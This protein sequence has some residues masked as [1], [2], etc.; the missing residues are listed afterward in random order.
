MFTPRYFAFASG[1]SS[2]SSNLATYNL[3]SITFG[4]GLISVPSSCSIRCSANLSSYVIKLMA[5][6]KCPNL[7][8]LPMRCK[9]VS[10][11]LGKSKL[12]TTFTA[13]TSI[14]KQKKIQSNFLIF[15]TRLRFIPLVK[16]SEQTRFRQRPAL[17]S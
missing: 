17:K 3:G 5:I 7:P 6:P 13:C 9:Y 12:I 4:I 2:S 1:V 14:P 15:E 11:I 8:D 10:A 16:R